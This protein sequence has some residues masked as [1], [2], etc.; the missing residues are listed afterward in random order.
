VGVTGVAPGSGSD[1]DV[2]SEDSDVDEDDVMGALK[3]VVDGGVSASDVAAKYDNVPSW[4]RV[5][6]VAVCGY[7]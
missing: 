1:S 4:V 3:E 5:L 7:L 6:C 2:Y